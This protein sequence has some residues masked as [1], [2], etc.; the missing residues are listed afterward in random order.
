M[1]KR[2]FILILSTI[3][4]IVFFVFKTNYDI[5]YVPTESMEPVINAGSIVIASKNNYEYNID[6]I[7]I[8]EKN[9]MR[10]IHRIIDINE[11]G[12]Y[13]FKGDN[14]EYVDSSFVEK[15]QIIGIYVFHSEIL[16][17]VYRNI[18]CII[19]CLVLSLFI[20]M[21]IRNKLKNKSV[22]TK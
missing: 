20:F 2:Y 9:G 16:G 6:D 21:L 3:M 8:Y 7:A 18:T 19:I 15:S 4:I 11:D 1:K 5:Y 10:I 22:I 17:K 13:V 12:T 14:N